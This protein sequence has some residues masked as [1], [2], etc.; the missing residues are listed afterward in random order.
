MGI[1]SVPTSL[2]GVSSKAQNIRPEIRQQAQKLA[3][4][5]ILDRILAGETFNPEQRA[6]AER[7]AYQSIVSALLEGKG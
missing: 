2:T 4:K 5:Q 3:Q 6:T 1:N 7:E